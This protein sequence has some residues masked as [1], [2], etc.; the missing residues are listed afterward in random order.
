MQVDKCTNCGTD[1][2]RVT[3]RGLCSRC[4]P[5]TRKLEQLENWNPKT[6]RAPKWIPQSLLRMPHNHFEPMRADVAKQLKDRLKKIRDLEARLREPVDSMMIESKLAWLAQ[7]AGVRN[8]EVMHGTAICFD[9]F[10]RE[11]RRTLFR[12]LNE[13]EEDIPLRNWIHWSRYLTE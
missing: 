1:R 10:A 2:F 4:Y 11:Q 12:L 8:R 7:K 9:S 3:A 6:G 13:I 5:L